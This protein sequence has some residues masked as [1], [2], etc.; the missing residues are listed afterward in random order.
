M[1]YKNDL[2]SER[3]LRNRSY[4]IP[5]N[6]KNRLS[7]NEIHIAAK[8]L[9]NTLGVIK[10]RSLYKFHPSIQSLTAQRMCFLEIIN[11]VST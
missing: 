7:P 4:F 5:A 9:L 10:L 11:D 2:H 6:I 3:D 8:N 1:G